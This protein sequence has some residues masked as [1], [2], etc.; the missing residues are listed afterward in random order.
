MKTASP[1]MITAALLCAALLLS[2]C[3]QATLV[4]DTASGTK[5]EVYCFS[6]GK[7]DAFLL[8]TEESAV[9]IDCGE[10]G[11]GK[12]ILA[13]MEEAGIESLD[14]LIITHFD[15]DHVGGA[16]KVIN[17]TPVETVL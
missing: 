12:E 7:A 2:G 10:K 4:A 17:S 16:A 13:Y 1:K 3:G 5:L 14:Y 6:A 11:F 15:K 9:L 8:Y